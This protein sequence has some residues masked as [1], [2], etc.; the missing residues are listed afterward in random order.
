VSHVPIFL[1][2][3]LGATLAGP[4]QR[5]AHVA[6]CVTVCEVARAHAPPQIED[7]WFAE[8]K[9][10]HFAMAFATTSFGHAGARAL[11][12]DA[13]V[14]TAIGAAATI[15]AS[16]GKEVYDRRTGGIFSARDL[17]WDA[18]GIVLGVIMLENAR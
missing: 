13:D 12:A 3:L 4:A 15:V 11:G 16:I 2:G 7:R 14:A 10:R 17:V 9:M 5:A 6:G 18:A 1:L 8:D